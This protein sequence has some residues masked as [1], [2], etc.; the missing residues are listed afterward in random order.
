MFERRFIENF[1]NGYTEK[2]QENISKDINIVKSI[3]FDMAK[4]RGHDEDLVYIGTAGGP[5]AGKTTALE[6][7]LNENQLVD[8]VYADPDQV[9][10][11]NMN[12]TYRKS[13]TNF[14]YAS[15]SSNRVA[16][17]NAYDKWRGASNYLCHEMLQIAFGNDDGK[18]PKYSVAHGTTA[19]S[20]HMETLYKNAKELGYKINLLLC[21]SQDE[22]REKA[23]TRR[24]QEQAFVQTDPKDV[25]SKGVDFPRRFDL[26]FNY[27]DELNFYWNDEH[28]HGTLPTPCAKIS[29]DNTSLSLTVLNESAWISFCKQYLTDIQKNNIPI[30]EVF[31]K[32]IPKAAL[33][34]NEKKAS[35]AFWENSISNNSLHR[36]EVRANNYKLG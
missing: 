9:S 33:F 13:L 6:T 15:A 19:T 31:E 5:G 4:A 3:T 23:I 8:Y 12:F 2:E 18:G 14:E 35:L 7:Y 22:T 34:E 28:N 20:P 24:E 25:I 1:L 21:Y 11:K 32:F 27:A 30:C 26:Y 16:L 10:L 36:H 29:K 17:K